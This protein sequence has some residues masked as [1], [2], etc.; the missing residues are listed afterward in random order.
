VYWLQEKK[1]KGTAAK[2]EVPT[3]LS[4]VDLRVGVI[5]TARKHENAESLYVESIDC[6]E[7]KLRQ[8]G[9]LLYT[10]IHLLA[11]VGGVTDG[12]EKRN[13]LYL[14]HGP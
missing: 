13:L 3:D 5:T 12:K 10:C 9:F 2:A 7:E 11:V 1:A 6:G 8:V 4:A 14:E